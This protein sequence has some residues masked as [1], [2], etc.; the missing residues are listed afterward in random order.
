[1]KRLLSFLSLALTLNAQALTIGA[2]NIRNFDYDQR[3]RIPTN[4][5]E[6]EKIL[7][8]L[9]AD[10]LSVEEIG[11]TA[12]FERFV[13]N[14]L[15]GYAVTL[16]RCGGAHGQ[17]VGILYKTSTVELLSFNEDL[18]TSDPG[19]TESCDAG[20]RPLGIGLFVVKA[21]KQKFYGITAHL[22]SGNNAED[23]AKRMK[24]YQII[25]DVI[26]ELKSKTAVADYYVAGDFNTTN[27]IT[28]GSD[29]KALTK[30]VSEL[31]MV[32]LTQN[33]ACSAYWWGGTDDG[34]ESPS[35]LDHII[36]TPGLMKKQTQAKAATHCQKVNCREVPTR[37][38]GVSYESVSDHCPVTA[39][40]Q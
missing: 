12:E 32:D 7:L 39:T 11:N 8:S 21:T 37:D 15:P 10:V 20:S 25:R 2:Y 9:N 24:Q 3:A 5:A 4:K 22:K 28:R 18:R 6:L 34:R 31:G 35:L 16:S 36:V 1:M 40:I 26:S 33:T 27:Y 38:L 17:K 29:Y 23:Q 14:K 19:G 13:A 30:V